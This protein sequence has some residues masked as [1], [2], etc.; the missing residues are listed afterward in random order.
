MIAGFVIALREGLEAAL[1]VGIVLAFL[2][3]TGARGQFRQVYAGIA[4]AITASLAFAMVF[5]FVSGGFTGPAAQIFEGLTTIIAAGLL[6]TMILW[7]SRRGPTIQ[8][9]LE[10]KADLASTSQA[11][12]I[13]SLIF[14]AVLRE[15]VETVLFL[16]A[17]PAEDPATLVG[18]ILGFA[19]AVGLG[20]LYFSGSKRF[21]LRTFFRAT[22]VLLVIFAAGML[23]YGIHELQEAQ[24]LPVFIEHV[25]D[26]NYVLNENSP[27]G[28]IL[29]GLVG[30][31]ANPSLLEVVAYVVYLVL[32]GLYLIREPLR[33]RMNKPPHEL[34]QS[35]DNAELKSSWPATASSRHSAER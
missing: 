24:V 3:K 34:P 31:N 9:D 26:F 11:L 8:R 18:A 15:G 17:L 4:G 30:Y 23:A 7:M 29:K 20:F 6:T 22:T 35:R 12:G 27:L 13:F 16:A 32:L 1:I 2:G 14:V 10:Q 33:R 28:L 19:V 5:Q 25:W 21:S